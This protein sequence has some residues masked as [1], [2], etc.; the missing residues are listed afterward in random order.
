[1]L[2]L[3]TVYQLLQLNYHL[4]KLAD[5]EGLLNCLHS[6]YEKSHHT[7]ADALGGKAVPKTDLDEAMH[8]ELEAMALYLQILFTFFAKLTPDAKPPPKGETPPL[9]S[10][11]HT[12]LIGVAAEYRLVSFCLHVLREYLGVHNA[13]V[14]GGEQAAFAER[15]LAELTPSIVTLLSGILAFHEPQ[16]VRHLPGFYPLFVDLMHC[17]SKEIR[18]LLRDIFS[19]RIGDVLHQ[20]QQAL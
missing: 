16:F 18:E 12:L 11:G 14:G 15:M 6:M 17:D 5:L 10:E 19:Q 2:L 9:G 4:M 8:L 20:R 7:V 3:S 13:A 1:V